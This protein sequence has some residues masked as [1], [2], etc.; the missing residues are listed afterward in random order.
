MLICELV[1]CNKSHIKMHGT[2][3]K[4]VYVLMKAID[5]NGSF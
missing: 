4:I 1:G 3:N 5:I 2:C